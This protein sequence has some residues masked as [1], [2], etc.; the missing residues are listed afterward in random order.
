MTTTTALSSIATASGAGNLPT[1]L[2][3]INGF[4][5]AVAG[6]L[7]DPA[8][9]SV[10]GF[11]T[12]VAIHFDSLDDLRNWAAYLQAPVT[13]HDAPQHSAVHYHADAKWG[14]I[15]GKMVKFHMVY[16]EDVSNLPD[17][18]YCTTDCDPGNCE[19]Q[20]VEQSGL[21]PRDCEASEWS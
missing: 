10:Y 14:P 1:S 11:D 9:I 17:V 3:G 5:R 20:H 21:L 6:D 16:I 18:H 7:P 12:E 19:V 13:P 2:A 8:S 4:I 15:N